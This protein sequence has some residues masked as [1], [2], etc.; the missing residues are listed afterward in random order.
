MVIVPSVRFLE[1]EEVQLSA[2]DNEGTWLPARRRGNGYRL[3]SWQLKK[4]LWRVASHQNL[5]SD[6]HVTKV[7]SS[8]SFSLNMTLQTFKPSNYVVNFLTCDTLQYFCHCWRSFQVCGCSSCNICGF[9]KIIV[10]YFILSNQLLIMVYLCLSKIKRNTYLTR[11][12]GIRKTKR[13]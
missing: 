10:H 7:I 3:T 11:W 4:C 12:N 5:P 2:D 8:R 6:V 1:R 13:V 9:F